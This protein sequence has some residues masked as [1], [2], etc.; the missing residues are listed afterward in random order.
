MGLEY[1]IDA[2]RA[3]VTI[4]GECVRASEWELLLARAIADPAWRPGL[5]ALLD[6]RHGRQSMDVA[7]VMETMAIVFRVWPTLGLRRA[8]IVTRH[9]ILAPALVAHALADAENIPIRSFTSYDVALEWLAATDV[10]NRG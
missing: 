8:A 5:V 1:A 10:P 4:T 3:V 6:Q 7:A 2:A 9:D